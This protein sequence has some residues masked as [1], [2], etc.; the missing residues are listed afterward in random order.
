M[1]MHIRYIT[2]NFTS[3]LNEINFSKVK[4]KLNNYAYSSIQ[5][6]TYSCSLFFPY[7]I[8]LNRHIRTNCSRSKRYSSKI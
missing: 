7:H 6:Y 1:N 8:I 5:L 3:N 2:Y 4:N